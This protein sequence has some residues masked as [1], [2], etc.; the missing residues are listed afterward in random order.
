[1]GHP[2]VEAKGGNEPE[3]DHG[4]PGDDGKDS[5]EK[6]LDSLNLAKVPGVSL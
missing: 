3:D 4:E 2:K 5:K 1:M 6:W